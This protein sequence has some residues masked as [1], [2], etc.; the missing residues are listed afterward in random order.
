MEKQKVTYKG[1]N[2]KIGILGGTFNP[3]HLGHLYMAK[4]AQRHLGLDRV[5]FMVCAIPPHKD[6]AF[7]TPV[8]HR[9]EMLE[10]MLQ[11]DVNFVI[12]DFEA[13]LKKKAYTYK[14]LRRIDKE[15]DD[16][17]SLYFI[18]GADS[19]MQL[20]LWREPEE[21]MRLTKFAVIPRGDFTK[22]ECVKKIALLKNTFNAKIQ[23]IDCE[24]MD[25]SST[26]VRD[27][28]DEKRAQFLDERVHEHIKENGLYFE[29]DKSR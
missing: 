21:L 22:D 27:A 24:K 4:Q 16:T 12:D 15:I 2:L 10:I 25:M 23:Y 26:M 28:I 29:D 18:I 14:S 11:D 5:V 3:V 7:D 19:L 17:S 13:H 1:K 9:L 6:L 20:D 8:S